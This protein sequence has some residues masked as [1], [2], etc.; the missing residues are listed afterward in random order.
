MYVSINLVDASARQALLVLFGDEASV[1]RFDL[2]CEASLM[3]C[4]SVSICTPSRTL[5]WPQ[6]HPK[7]TSDLLSL[8]RLVIDP[9][10]RTLLL[11]WIKMNFYYLRY[12][13]PCTGEPVRFW[14]F[15]IAY[16]D[17][18]V[19]WKKVNKEAIVMGKNQTYLRGISN[20]SS[21][22]DMLPQPQNYT[23]NKY[24]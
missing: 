2:F 20:F 16:D 23:T 8:I 19:V 12:T 10:I 11:S 24:E 17:G 21:L 4:D 3:F 5:L 22:P 15:P 1:W 14:R 6:T 13:S 7:R 18:T 9:T